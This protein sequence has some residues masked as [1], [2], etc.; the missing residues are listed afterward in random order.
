MR[1][2][3]SPTKRRPWPQCG[4]V[5]HD[6]QINRLPGNRRAIPAS[7][8]ISSSPASHGRTL[9]HSLGP[10]A[11]AA[12]MIEGFNGSLRPSRRYRHRLPGNR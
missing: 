10:V 11:F 2:A 6:E 8:G 1:S 5:S 3:G 12:P 9:G 7:L 4:R